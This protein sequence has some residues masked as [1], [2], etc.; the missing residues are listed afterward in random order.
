MAAGGGVENVGP[1]L[2]QSAL[3]NGSKISRRLSAVSITP[4]PLLIITM[5][6]GPLRL[7]WVAVDGTGDTI[8]A[9]R[10]AD[11][12]MEKGGGKTIRRL[13]WRSETKR[14]PLEWKANPGGAKKG[15]R[16]GWPR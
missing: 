9:R 13:A 8:P 15:V 12:P 11:M 4:G 16:A 7:L 10:A 3:L 1:L 2:F 14:F 6:S 5:P